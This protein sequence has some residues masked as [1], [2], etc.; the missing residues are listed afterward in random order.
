MS[1]SRAG[2]QGPRLD[3]WVPTGCCGTLPRGPGR[4]LLVG[5]PWE[6]PSAAAPGPIR[7]CAS[8]TPRRPVAPGV[9]LREVAEG[10]PA[11]T[12]SRRATKQP[13]EGRGCWGPKTV[14]HGD[15]SSH[16]HGNAAGALFKDPQPLE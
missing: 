4:A 14:R 6:V 13:I 2:P 11:W 10:A 3:Y 5:E 15:T 7:S 1:P 8:P 12:A 16:A 9:C